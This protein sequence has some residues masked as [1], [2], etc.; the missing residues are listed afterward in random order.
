[1]FWLESLAP[2]DSYRFTS[3]KANV[4]PLDKSD[5]TM[6]VVRKAAECQL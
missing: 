1:M 3:Q 5:G 2:E 4:R 6:E